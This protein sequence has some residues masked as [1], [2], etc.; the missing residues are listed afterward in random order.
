MSLLQS[1]STGLDFKRDATKT[2]FFL[3]G[4]KKH[5]SANPH[6]RPQTQT[7]FPHLSPAVGC[8]RAADVSALF[9]QIPFCSL[10]TMEYCSLSLTLPYPLSVCSA[11]ISRISLDHYLFRAISETLF[12]PLQKR[13]AICKAVQ[14]VEAAASSP[15][16]K[17]LSI[18][19]HKATT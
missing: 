2:F 10:V 14:C 8:K 11:S 13:T 17:S 16:E 15:K 3:K 18:S 6:T 19:L 9:M 5:S 1:Q 12:P 7:L 4:G